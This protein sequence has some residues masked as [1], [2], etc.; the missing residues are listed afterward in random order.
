MRRPRWGDVASEALS[1]VPAVVICLA[2]QRVGAVAAARP[3]WRTMSWIAAKMSPLQTSHISDGSFQLAQGGRGRLA[4]WLADFTERKKIHLKKKEK[5]RGDNLISRE[6]G[7][8]A[9]TP[10]F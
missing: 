3:D 6:R 4:G 5:T 2:V 9:E 8:F 10:S 7:N 1:G